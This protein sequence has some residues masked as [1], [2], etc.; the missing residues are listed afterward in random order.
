MPSTHIT[1]ASGETLHVEMSA[2]DLKAALPGAGGLAQ[3]PTGGGHFIYVNP[4]H[5]VTARDTTDDEVHAE[6]FS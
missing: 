5:I 4:V 1:L 2:E 6:V 3:L